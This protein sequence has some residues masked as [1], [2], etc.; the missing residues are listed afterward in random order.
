MVYGIGIST[1]ISMMLYF[2]QDCLETVIVVQSLLWSCNVQQIFCLTC[3]TYAG[4]DDNR[5]QIILSSRSHLQPGLEIRKGRCTAPFDGSIWPEYWTLLDL[6]FNDWS[7]DL[8]FLWFSVSVLEHVWFTGWWFLDVS[9][10]ICLKKWNGTRSDYI[11]TIPQL[12]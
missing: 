3:Q 2:G 5:A 8:G 1:W 12:K 9:R 11:S 6:Y 4:T 7:L 10:M